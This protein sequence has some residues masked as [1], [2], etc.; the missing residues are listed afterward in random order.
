MTP[1]L[2]TRRA[3]WTCLMYHRVPAA[4]EDADY[5]AVP[6]ARFAEQLDALRAA[7]MRVVSLERAVSQPRDRTVAITFD[8]GD[9]SQFQNALPELVARGMTATFFVITARV[10]MPGYVTWKE[11]GAMARAGMSIQSHTHTH[12]FLS[13]LSRDDAARELAEAR[14]LL[15]AHLGQR[16][17]ILALPNGDAPRGWTGRDYAALGYTRV[18]TSRWGANHGGDARLIRR[19]TVRRDTSARAFGALITGESSA[20]S[21]EALRLLALNRVRAA[22]GPS[23]YAR[24]RRLVLST[25]GR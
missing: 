24:A 17:T 8:D 15:D 25:L 23:R 4:A 21:A 1:L 19:Y 18:A 10:G 20:Y 13:E 5:F 9:E 6:R 2:P 7:G 14:R 22:V 16:T 3:R 11:L 12:P